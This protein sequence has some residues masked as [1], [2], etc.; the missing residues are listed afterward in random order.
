[1]TVK[2]A[3]ILILLVAFLV[4]AEVWREIHRFKVTRYQIK[5]PDFSGNRRSVKAV[6]LSDLHN[7]V[8]GENNKD[9]L[10]AI[11]KEEPDLIL[12]GGDMLVAKAGRDWS[13]AADLMRRLPE[14]APVYCANGNHEQRMREHPEI[15]GDH[16]ERYRKELVD[17]GVHLLI[18]ASEEVRVNDSLFRIFGMELPAECYKKGWKA[19]T[20]EKEEI[21]ER[22]GSA[23]G[24]VYR[25]LL[26]HHPRFAEIYWDWGADLVLSGH[27][28]GGVA[29]LPFIG[30]VISPQ[31]QLFPHYS[32][33]CYQ[34]GDKEIVVSK[35]LGTHTINIRFWNPA[36]LVVLEIDGK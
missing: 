26:A 11:R 35:G 14:I 24:H 17:A 16:Y 13:A 32:G 18:N 30:G 1:M 6:F 9:L 33:D 25:I 23:G 27:L 3:G 34:N 2:V 7:H 31:F 29:R 12:V 15:Y 22:L 4:F 21:E 10:E 28:H 19:K 36:E 8:Y 5:D 20:L